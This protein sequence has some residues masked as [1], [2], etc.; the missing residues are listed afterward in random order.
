MQIA[1]FYTM[2]CDKCGKEVEKLSHFFV[3]Q[4]PAFTPDILEKKRNQAPNI[5]S[6]FAKGDTDECE[7]GGVIKT[8][9]IDRQYMNN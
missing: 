8:I 6:V 4:D 5:A 3:D 7:C 2:K 1:T 9:R